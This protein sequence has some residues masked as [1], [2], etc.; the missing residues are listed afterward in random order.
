M[1]I[2]VFLALFLG[3]ALLGAWVFMMLFNF[4]SGHM[5]GPEI[6]IW[7]ALAISVILGMINNGRRQ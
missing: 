3:W 6:T 5:G 1:A 4:I 2:L 7:V